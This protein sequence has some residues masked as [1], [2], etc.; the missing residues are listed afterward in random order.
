MWGSLTLILYYDIVKSKKTMPEYEL[1]L[2][3]YIRIFRKRKTVILSVFLVVF[4]INIIYGNTRTPIF[5]ASTTVKIVI[6]FSNA[7]INMPGLSKQ[8][9]ADLL[10]SQATIITS[11]QLIEK[12]ARE[13]NLIPQDSDQNS[14]N[15]IVGSLVSNISA[16]ALPESNVVKITVKNTDPKKAKDIAN[17]IAEVYVTEAKNEISRQAAMVV[18]FIEG[19][20]AEISKRLAAS[21]EALKKHNE[22]ID[23]YK[24]EQLIEIKKR[25][26]ANLPYLSLKNKLTSNE[27]KLRELLT[28]YTESHPNVIAIKSENESLKKQLE[29]FQKKDDIQ[30]SEVISTIEIPPNL[31]LEEMRLKREITNDEKLYTLLKS[32]LDDARINEESKKAQSVTIVDR[33][34]E[35]RTPININLP[36]III[37]GLLTGALA[38]IIAAFI[39]EQL[40]FSVRTIEEV[41]K[42]TGIQVIGLIP[43]FELPDE[44]KKSFKETLLENLR[45]YILR[46]ERTANP[47]QATKRLLINYEEK[48]IVKEAFRM[49]QANLFQKLGIDKEL[50]KK[51]LVSSSSPM[52][53]KSMTSINLAIIIAQMGHKVMLIDA[54]LRK[55]SIHKAF[56]FKKS[57]PGLTEILTASAPWE[58]TARNLVDILME[59]D[60]DQALKTTGLDNLSIITSGSRTPNST[61]LLSSEEMDNLLKDLSANFE[62]I[63]LDTPPALPL[64][65]ALVLAPKVDSVLLVHKLG[66]ISRQV[67]I[68]TKEEFVTLKANVTGIVLND[69]SSLFR[70]DSDYYYKYYQY[71][72]YYSEEE[73]PR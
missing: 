60:W 13:L 23:K 67:L 17:K 9:A 20:L 64:A 21:E 10:N 32:K 16:E 15:A 52:E 45:H 63:I 40:D 11:R 26:Q 3:D 62:V 25:Q 55:P 58:E 73:N 2:R 53:G 27:D 30:D 36:L 1:N 65:D 43:Y 38:G 33:A 56:G 18:N 44:K 39:F 14:I 31:Q 12:V 72:Q 34:V 37:F 19:R 47:V 35:S 22:G 50:G 59:A 69:I 28:V 46:K 41:E 48:S 29:T 7:D 57:Y 49:L 54:D 8:P 70:T 51:I 42:V 68:R 6:E 24:R 5:Q 71:K 61:E 4:L 66:K